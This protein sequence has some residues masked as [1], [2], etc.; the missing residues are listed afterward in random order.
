MLLM[1]LSRYEDNKIYCSTL[2]TG[3]QLQ[4]S[5]ITRLILQPLMTPLASFDFGRML[6]VGTI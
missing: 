2:N 1:Q 4:L 6:A 5:Q 3:S